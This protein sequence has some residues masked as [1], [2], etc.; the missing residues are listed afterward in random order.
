MNDV[1]YS[2]ATDMRYMLKTGSR[3]AGAVIVELE[4]AVRGQK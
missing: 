2:S 1:H 4:Q 3:L